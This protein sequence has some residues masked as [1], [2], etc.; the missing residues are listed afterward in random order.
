MADPFGYP[1]TWAVFIVDACYDTTY[2]SGTDPRGATQDYRRTYE[3][4][5]DLSFNAAP[6]TVAG[7]T[8]IM[9]YQLLTV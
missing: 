4:S 6:L 9:K 8:P 5:L 7:Q 1:Y 2:S 3:F